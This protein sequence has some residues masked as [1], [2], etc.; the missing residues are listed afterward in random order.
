MTKTCTPLSIARG[1]QSLCSIRY[2]FSGPLST[3]MAAKSVKMPGVA[4]R[5][6]AAISPLRG[7]ERDGEAGLCPDEAGIT[8][9]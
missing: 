4:T 2:V 3:N 9:C 8:Q 7:Q 5:L 1:L 6:G